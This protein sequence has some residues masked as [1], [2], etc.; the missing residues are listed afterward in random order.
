VVLTVLSVWSFGQAESGAINGI[1]T[2]KTGAVVVGA[3]VTATSVD[4]GLVR[5]TTTESA[6]EYAITDLP[7]KLYG[8]TIEAKG[9]QKYTYQLKVGVG[10]MNDVSAKLAVTGASATMEVT[11]S[12]EMAVVNTENQT[13]SQTINSQQI[14]DLPTLTRN[15]YDLVAIAG[16]VTEDNN[17][18]RG[19]GYAINGAR[20]ADTDILLDGGENVDL[21]TATV[22]QSVPLDT[23][24]E[25][26]VLTNNF[27]AE[28]G[29]AGGGVINVATKSGTNDFHGSLY[30]FNRL[31]T[32]AANTYNND[33]N[34]IGK[35][36]FTRNQFG[37]SIGG[38]IVKNK[39]FFFSGTEWT[40]I[41]SGATVT[42]DILDPAFLALPEVN[43]N[44][45]AFFNNFG[46]HLRPD[47]AVLQNVN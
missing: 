10:S 20:S 35:P 44:T 5:T 3:T 9:F 28:Y 8:I 25:F 22:G 1:V 6:G 12:A 26:S 30:E 31:S 4:T 37:Y 7:P 41:R 14:M 32:L 2:D 45:K 40:R 36:G 11:G 23:V 42:Q 39:L 27:T 47:L 43:G 38:P 16:N 19:A 34:D 18:D 13:L 33:A 24:Q 46:S 17:S 29:R 21:F 15:P